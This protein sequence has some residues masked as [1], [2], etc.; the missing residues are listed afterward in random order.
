MKIENKNNLTLIQVVEKL[1]ENSFNISQDSR[2]KNSFFYVKGKQKFNVSSFGK[3]VMVT[4]LP[5]SMVSLILVIL[6]F[7]GGTALYTWFVLYF[8]SKLTLLIGGFVGAIL[9]IIIYSTL[10]KDITKKEVK[11]IQEIINK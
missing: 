6:L 8:I 2:T 9:Y 11:K 3:K 4:V 10:N 1:V 7:V 5:K